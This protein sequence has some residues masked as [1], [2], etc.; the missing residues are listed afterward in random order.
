M[1]TGYGEE[2]IFT[3]PMTPPGKAPAFDGTDD[4]VNTSHG[5]R[6][7]VGNT[8]TIE[9]WIKP[10]SLSG[11][12]GVFSMRLNNVA[13]SFQ[14]E[15]GT[16]SSGENRVAVTGVNTRVA[17]MDDHAPAPNQWTHIAYARGETGAG[18][19]TLYVNG[20]AQTLISD[21][22]YTFINNSSDK[23]IGSGTL[24]GQLFP[25]QIDEL[26]VWSV[27]RTED[28]IRDNM[29]RQLNGD[30]A[31]LVAYYSCNQASGTNLAD[32]TA[33]TNDGMLVN[34]PV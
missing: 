27:A 11:R 3:T 28:E 6:F 19:H 24:G 34:G 12:R 30:E 10:A 9:A 1:G 32:Q 2:R 22:D 31:G 7:N 18:T 8:L 20:V 5:A 14:L 23:V 16:G 33:N 21:A 15:V 13:G 4:Y 26:R 29:H 25:G 17:Q